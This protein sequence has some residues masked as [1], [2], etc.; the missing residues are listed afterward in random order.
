M[1]NPY[2]KRTLTLFEEL[3]NIE[4]VD[5][6]HL[7][8]NEFLIPFHQY[9]QLITEYKGL[10]KVD[11]I[12]QSHIERRYAYHIFSGTKQNPSRNK[13]LTF[14]NAM[15]L[16]LDETQALLQHSR[17]CQ[18]CPRSPADSII[19]SAIHQRLDVPQTNALL[20]QFSQNDCLG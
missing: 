9:L 17:H 11:V 3:K 12:R 13:V 20:R 19:I 2:I 16:N 14:A 5:Y 15:N 1:I 18:L 6:L 4:I 10:T 8:Q 7:N